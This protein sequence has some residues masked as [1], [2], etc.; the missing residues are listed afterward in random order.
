MVTRSSL[1]TATLASVLAFLSAF[2]SVAAP[3]P[4]ADRIRVVSYNVQFLPGIAALANDRGDPA[5]RAQRLGEV[6]AA[7]DVVCLQEVFEPK[8][9]ETILAGLRAAWGDQFHAVVHEP[10]GDGRGMGGLAVASRFPIVAS[11]HWYFRDM[12][13]FDGKRPD[14]FVAKGVLHAKIAR[15]PDAPEDAFDVFATHVVAGKDEHRPAQ[16]AE[17]AWF[18]RKHGDPSRPALIAGDMNTDGEAP[19]RAKPDSRYNLMIALFGDARPKARLLDVWPELRGDEVAGTNNWR[20]KRDG[21]KKRIDYILLLEEEL[22]DARLGP[23]LR[24]ES[25]AV[26]PFEDPRVRTLADHNAVEADFQWRRP[27]SPPEKG[28]RE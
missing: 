17:L 1:R 3:D 16:F 15:S 12:S 10:P 26:N 23:V 28:P 13:P 5:Y 11:H 24:P 7:Y 6:L 21:R 20:D 22:P 27:N 25:I 19:E 18:V 4:P 8:A 2:R 9:R 14:D